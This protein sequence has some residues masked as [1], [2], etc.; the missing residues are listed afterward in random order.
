MLVASAG[1]LEPQQFACHFI[2]R[3]RHMPLLGRS[4]VN[5]TAHSPAARRRSGWFTDRPLGLKFGA[6]LALLALVAVGLTVLAVQRIDSLSA[7]Q[8]DL[9]E[10]HVVAFEDLANL[11]RAYQGDRAR[12]I[13]L[14]VVDDVARTQLRQELAER[15]TD[16]EAKLEA[17][18][19]RTEDPDKL[20]DP[21][22]GAH[23]LLRGG[24]PAA[25]PGRRRG[26]RRSGCSDRD[27][28]APG[29]DR[30]GDGRLR[31]RPVPAL[32][33]WPGA[34]RSGGEHGRQ[35]RPG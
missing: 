10:N 14:A 1:S 5:S 25:G 24:R 23:G 19:A 20:R 32:R 13:S 34:G 17:Y 22:R 8:Q 16:I 7:D 12:Y 27:R 26:W 35:C 33:G 29:R 4:S 31:P 11:Q 3:M 30:R 9:Y 15:R 2:F 21:P 28:T 6:A 18:A